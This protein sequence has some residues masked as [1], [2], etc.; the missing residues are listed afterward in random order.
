MDI[1]PEVIGKEY[2]VLKSRE[3]SAPA[4]LTDGKLLSQLHEAEKAKTARAEPSPEL[5]ER[6]TRLLEEARRRF[7]VSTQ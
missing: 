1:F 6:A 2:I 3:A 4:E 7:L 5:E